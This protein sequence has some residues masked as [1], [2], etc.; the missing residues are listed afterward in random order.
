MKTSRMIIIMGIIVALLIAAA[1]LFEPLGM[2]FVNWRINQSVRSQN[3]TCRIFAKVLDQDNNPVEG[4]NVELKYHVQE[5]FY[6]QIGKKAYTTTDRDGR[7][8]LKFFGTF[9]I[10][11]NLGL[12]KPGYWSTTTLEDRSWRE[13]GASPETK[14]SKSNPIVFRMWRV[15]H[16]EANLFRSVA[17]V[18]P[19][20]DGTPYGVDLTVHPTKL[21]PDI[22]PSATVIVS[23]KNLQREKSKDRDKK[24]EPV[25]WVLTVEVPNGG[26]IQTDEIFP[27]RPPEAGYSPARWELHV[28]A[29]DPNWRDVKKRFYIKLENPTRYGLIQVTANMDPIRDKVHLSV[30]GR[31]NLSGSRNLEPERPISW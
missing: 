16:P 20:P 24:Y 25:D 18:D 7:F 14:S 26:L 13:P 17:G 21:T 11:G 6:K 29:T 2:L 4:V 12:S 31:L 5:G 15:G 8:Y 1:V 30:S 28:N 19:P 9:S 3:H 23:A 10:T 22:D 27:Y